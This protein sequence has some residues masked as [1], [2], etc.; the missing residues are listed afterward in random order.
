M[1]VGKSVCVGR[2]RCV[3]VGC[4]VSGEAMCVR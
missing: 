2:E 3:S 1:L 4:C